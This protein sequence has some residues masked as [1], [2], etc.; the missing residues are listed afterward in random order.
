[1]EVEEKQE[2]KV[3]RLPCGLKPTFSDFKFPEPGASQEQK[4]VEEK[5][6]RLPN[7]QKAQFSD[8]KFDDRPRMVLNFTFPFLSFTTER[9]KIIPSKVLQKHPT[10]NQSLMKNNIHF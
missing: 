4:V 7:G 10:Q 1:M 6:K 8:F 2:E 5:P 3:E 9:T